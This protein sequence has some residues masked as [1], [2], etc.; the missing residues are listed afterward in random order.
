MPRIAVIDDDPV[1]HL[2]ITEMG[3]D[4]MP[5]AEF[6]CFTTLT[7]FLEADVTSFT[8]IFLDR[9]LPPYNE[10][11][12]TLP[13]IAAAG[14]AGNVVMMTAFDPGIETGEYDFQLIGPIDKLQIIQPETLTAVLDGVYLAA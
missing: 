12:E 10:Y 3:S 14:F 4:V 13:E 11:H 6:V 9:R 2:L 5:D 1:E 8:H 7:A